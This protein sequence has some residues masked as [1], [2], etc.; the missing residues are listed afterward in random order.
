MYIRMT[1]TAQYFALTLHAQ[2]H[3]VEYSVI[4]CLLIRSSGITQ[5]GQLNLHMCGR[6]TPPQY[7]CGKYINAVWCTNMKM[8]D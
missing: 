2:V 5:L 8:Y 7:G 3:M 1:T 4:A 6:S